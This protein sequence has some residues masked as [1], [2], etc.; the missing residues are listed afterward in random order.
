M[1]GHEVTMYVGEVI[2]ASDAAQVTKKLTC[3]ENTDAERGPI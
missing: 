3:Q 2:S 1:R